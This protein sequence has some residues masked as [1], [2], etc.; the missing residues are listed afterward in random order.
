MFISIIQA[1]TLKL[2]LGLSPANIVGASLYPSHLIDWHQDL[3]RRHVLG[4]THSDSPSATLS[5][6]YEKAARE[7]ILD[8]VDA[9]PELYDVILTANATAGLKLVGECYECKEK[10]VIIGMDAH[11][12]VNGLALSARNRGAKVSIIPYQLGGSVMI[13]E[14][15]FV[16]QSRVV[17][18]VGY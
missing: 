18:E 3:L 4:N 1:S 17:K 15:L 5:T 2:H 16:S 9:D 6:A 8:F 13:G 11:N 7:A 12:S 10:R 14:K